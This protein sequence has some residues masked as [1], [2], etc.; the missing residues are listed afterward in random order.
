MSRGNQTAKNYNGRDL[1]SYIP[2]TGVTT[3]NSFEPK[4]ALKT[5]DASVGY[6]IVSLPSFVTA[7]SH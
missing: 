5:F 4:S 1:F 7:A 6:S 2:E 3:E